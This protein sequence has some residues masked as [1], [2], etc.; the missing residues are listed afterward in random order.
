MLWQQPPAQV[1][2]TLAIL[3]SAKGP[4]PPPPPPS[5]DTEGKFVAVLDGHTPR[6]GY[7]VCATQW[8]LPHRPMCS[9]RALA[10]AL[11]NYQRGRPPRTLR[12]APPPPSPAL[13]HELCTTGSA[14]NHRPNCAV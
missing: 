6:R 3:P 12:S 13:H 2:K 1:R 4:T 7:T 10:L 5:F 11:A 9:P 8:R 14:Q